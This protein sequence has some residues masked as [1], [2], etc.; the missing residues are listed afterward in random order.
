MLKDKLKPTTEYFGLANN[1]TQKVD[2]I[3]IQPKLNH[4]KFSVTSLP[5][6]LG[7][8]QLNTD[9]YP[10]R[11]FYFLDFNTDNMELNFRNKGVDDLN[12]LKHGRSR[13]K[14][15]QV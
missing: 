10:V 14:S 2:S 9:S 6:S 7:C 8:R 5:V 13:N 3:L 4:A 1:Q 12:Q 11:V 15:N